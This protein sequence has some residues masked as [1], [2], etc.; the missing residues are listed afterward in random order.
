[1]M[2]LFVLAIF[3]FF[4]FLSIKAAE[5]QLSSIAAEKERERILWLEGGHVIYFF[6]D[7]TI[8]YLR[9]PPYE[10]KT[11]AEWWDNIEHS[12]PDL[13]FYFIYIAISGAIVQ[14]LISWNPC[15]AILKL[16]LSILISLRIAKQEK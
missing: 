5:L 9:H 14:L 2:H 15:L 3:A 8:V 13:K 16:L 6:K 7:Q 10:R 1:M 11:W 12:Q 4:P